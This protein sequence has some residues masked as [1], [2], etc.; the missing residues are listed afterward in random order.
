M[1]KPDLDHIG[2]KLP[3]SVTTAVRVM[4]AIDKEFPGAVWVND[5]E[6]GTDHLVIG[7]KREL[8]GDD[9]S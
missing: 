9:G 1:T 8:E 5:H 4:Q 6:M 7:V 2:I 3:L